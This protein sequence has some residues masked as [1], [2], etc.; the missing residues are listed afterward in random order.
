MR[1]PGPAGSGACPAPLSA[2]AAGDQLCC[3]RCLQLPRHVQSHTSPTGSLHPGTHT[4]V[5]AQ[6]MQG[7]GRGGHRAAPRRCLGR[8]S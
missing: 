8:P 7:K 4:P 6:A 2:T 1:S 3:T 5:H